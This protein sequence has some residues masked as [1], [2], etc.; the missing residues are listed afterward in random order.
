[1]LLLQTSQFAPART[2]G[3]LHQPLQ[4]V[5]LTA[6]ICCDNQ[7]S[8]QEAAACTT[9]GLIAVQQL[10]AGACCSH[11]AGSHLLLPGLPEG[12]L[13]RQAV[14]CLLQPG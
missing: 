3:Q 5:Q 10:G 6:H 13:R 9:F 1:M 7:T 14:V 12:L 2:G 4:P 11:T 8:P